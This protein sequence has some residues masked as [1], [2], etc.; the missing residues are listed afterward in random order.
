[1]SATTYSCEQQHHP[2]ADVGCRSN[3]LVGLEL[4]DTQEQILVAITRL[5]CKLGVEHGK[6]AT[7]PD[8]RREIIEEIQ[9]LRTMR[10]DLI[11]K[12]RNNSIS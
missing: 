8:R 3:S 10:D 2:T 7:T 4:N 11:T 1:M 12:W 5:H 6:A 9:S